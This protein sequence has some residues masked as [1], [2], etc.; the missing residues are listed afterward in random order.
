MEPSPK[1]QER[2][3]RDFVLIRCL[4]SKYVKYKTNVQI[5]KK[6]KEIN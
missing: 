6:Q 5:R 2:L 1:E 3:E 4:C